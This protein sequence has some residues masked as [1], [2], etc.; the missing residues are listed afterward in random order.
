MN[1]KKII[2]IFSISALLVTQGFAQK[3]VTD[4][5]VV[6]A[7]SV[8]KGKDQPGIADAFDGAT[9]TVSLKGAMARTDLK[10]NLRNQTIFYNSKDGSAVILKESGN[11]KYMINLTTGQW[12]QYNKKFAGLTFKNTGETKII[13][14]LNCVKASGVLKDG[15]TLD[16][17]YCPDLKPLASGYEYAFRDLPG[18]PLQYE[19][20]T[21][22]IV[23]RYLATSV[24]SS[25]VNAS[26]FDLPKSGYKILDFNQ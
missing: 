3:M 9:L 26:R 10:S 16:V 1:Y 17:Y 13:E 8:V 2:T 20:S 5:T 7:V 6:Y 22:N 21:G 19:I 11:E 4:G 18:L 14:G 23:V 12:Q 15:S 24:Q 25:P